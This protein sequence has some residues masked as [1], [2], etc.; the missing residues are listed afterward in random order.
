M[1]IYCIFNLN[2]GCCI[3]RSCVSYLIIVIVAVLFCSDVTRCNPIKFYSK[4]KKIPLRITIAF[5]TICSISPNLT[6]KS[7]SRFLTSYCACF[8]GGAMQCTVLK[9]S[10]IKIAV[11]SLTIPKGKM[12]AFLHW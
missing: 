5:V 12:I 1:C 9:E 3:I 11:F 4:N 6:L 7:S 10:Q 2:D 8:Q